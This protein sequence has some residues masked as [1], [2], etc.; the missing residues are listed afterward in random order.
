MQRTNVDKKVKEIFCRVVG[1]KDTEVNDETAYDSYEPWDSLKHLEFVAEFEEEW[2]LDFEMDDVIAME[3]FKKVKDI[4][5][6]YIE[7]K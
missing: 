3:T 4:V 7:N 1:V 2:D 6:K 5:W